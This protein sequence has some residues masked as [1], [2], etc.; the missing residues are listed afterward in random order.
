M[1]PSKKKMSFSIAL[2]SAHFWDSQTTTHLHLSS[3]KLRWWGNETGFTM[4]HLYLDTQRVYHLKAIMAK[5]EPSGKLGLGLFSGGGGE[6]LVA[7]RV[8]DFHLEQFNDEEFQCNFQLPPFLQVPLVTRAKALSAGTP[9]CNRRSSWGRFKAGESVYLS[10][11]WESR[12][13]KW[14]LISEEKLRSMYIQFLGGEKPEF[15]FFLNLNTH[16]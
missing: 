13:A 10:L 14:A 1:L 5:E 11:I 9:C 6:L 16:S 15:S 12:A 7:G 3:K 4:F 8:I 2:F